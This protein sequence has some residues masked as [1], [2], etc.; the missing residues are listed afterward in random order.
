MGDPCP[1]MISRNS[2]MKTVVRGKKKSKGEEMTRKQ[3]DAGLP[4]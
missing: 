3:R 1:R 2:L 4:D